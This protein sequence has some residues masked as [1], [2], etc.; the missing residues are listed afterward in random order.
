MAVDVRRAAPG[1]VD[2]LQ[3]LYRRSSLWWASDRDLVAAHPE[4][5]G[6]SPEQV[7]RGWVRVVL[8]DGRIAGFST[9]VPGP[10]P[11]A[12]LEA[13]FVEPDRMGRGL[14]RLLVEDAVVTAR[15][16]GWRGLR[17][18]ANA[19]ALGFYERMGFVATG[20][21]A[22]EFGTGQAMLLEVGAPDG[23]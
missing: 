9:V 13:L 4:W 10:G 22:L 14:G 17:V 8:D 12:E 2:E 5:V 23:A 21:V 1:E 16:A 15:A 19:N 6:P 18:V 3:R 11:G 7:E 20:T